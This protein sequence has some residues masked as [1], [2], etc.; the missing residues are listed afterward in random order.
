MH[1]LAIPA[2]RPAPAQLKSARRRLDERGEV[3]DTLL[4]DALARSWRR[5]LAGGLP[6]RGRVFGAMH[7]SAPQL[8]R[9]RERSAPLLAHAGPVLDL[10]M[11]AVAAAS[12]LLLLA[13]D[14]GTVL[15]ATGDDRFAD[16][17]GRVALRPGARWS[18]ALRGT[19]GIGTA[20]ADA[21]PVVVHGA[22]HY[23]ARNAFLSCC[24]AP[25]FD[26]AGAVVGVVDVTGDQRALNPGTLP[27]VLG[28][29]GMAARLVS[30]RLF[31]ALPGELWRVELHAQPAGLG[32]PAQGLLALHDDGT[33]AAADAQARTLLGRTLDA[34]VLQR[35]G[36]GLA[37]LRA[38]A[39]GLQPRP[40]TLSD[41]RRLW[42]R[43]HS[44][45]VRAAAPRP[46][47]AAAAVPA[48][49]VAEI[50][51]EDAAGLQPVVAVPEDSLVLEPHDAALRAQVQRARRVAGR[52]VALV[53]QGETGTGKE[54][55]A[56]A[57]HRQGPR[58][59]GRFVAVGASAL[60]GTLLEAELFGHVGG[61]FTGARSDGAPGLVLQ[62]DGGT[63]F[64]DD[65]AELPPAAQAA[66]LRVLQ[67]RAVVP[68][69]AAQPLSVDFDLMCA[70][71]VPLR[72][73]VAGG[74]LRED[75]YWRLAGLTV[76][77]PPLRARDDRAAVLAQL[78]RAAAGDG[79]LP[80]LEP[81]LRAAI[82]RHPWPGN[83]R[84]LAQAL[85]TACALADRG[86]PIGIRHLPD[87]LAA[88]LVAC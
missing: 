39:D 75:L 61:A 68:L 81:E 76:V 12:G 32:S 17:A 56:R 58:R 80:R 31:D 86:G 4:G 53:I 69:G 19:N 73:A 88:Q 7:A 37:E 11:P 63:L 65:V 87:E 18:E 74:R 26:P 57:L 60:P 22:E 70:T 83:L 50:P 59:A 35:L 48:P 43:V 27:H 36:L 38:A 66:L 85:R 62:A 49:G 8:A 67:E 64:L 54:V 24:A 55:L 84:Q 45:A 82:E 72:D 30:L 28:L 15:Q 6:P 34:A 46:A 21:R 13:D 5:S 42:L 40:W 20:L 47:P 78:L 23:L 71:R 2:A 14:E 33:L 10:V 51:L 29:A 1:P 44:P 52:G 25:V 79:P 41:G 3:D 77:L 16:R 9:S